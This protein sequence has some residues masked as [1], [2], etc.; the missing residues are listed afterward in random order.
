MAAEPLREPDL[1]AWLSDAKTDY[2][3]NWNARALGGDPDH[4]PEAE[5]R[6][7]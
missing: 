1:T 4:D 7:L 6:E 3:A 2:E 5:T